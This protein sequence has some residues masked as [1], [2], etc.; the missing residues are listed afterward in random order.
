[1][2]EK[3]KALVLSNTNAGYYSVP[4]E[5][6]YQHQF[7]KS[8]QTSSLAAVKY[9]KRSIVQFVVYLTGSSAVVSD[10]NFIYCLI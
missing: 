7:N 2:L 3:K 9:N 1:M 10:V 4:T 5:I 6:H 8:Y